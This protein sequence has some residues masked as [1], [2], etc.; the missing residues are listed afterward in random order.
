[1]AETIPTPAWAEKIIAAHLAVAPASAV[2]HSE[3]LTSERYFIW[4]EDGAND[5]GADNG[6]A[7]RAVT[8]ATDLYSKIEFDPWAEAI[9]ESFEAHGVAWKLVSSGYE[10]DTEFY[11]WSYD[12]EVC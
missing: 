1:M 10:E 11:H 2:S 3:K 4:E 9:G 7:E 8:G 12:W 5:L 6:H